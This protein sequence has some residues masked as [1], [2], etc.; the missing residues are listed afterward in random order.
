MASDKY[1]LVHETPSVEDYMRVRKAAG[2]GAKSL[3][4]AKR[5]LP[6]TLF[7]AQARYKGEVVAFCRLI[8]DDG[9]FYAVADGVVM[10]EHQ[11]QGLGKL[12]LGE[13]VR[14]FKETAPPGAY[15]MGISVSPD[16]VKTVGLEKVSPPE[17]GVYCWLP[18]TWDD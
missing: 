11:R 15:L 18:A 1:E 16:F 7:A 9:L 14:H 4:A 13:C 17:V 12:V 10:P 2:L 6:N 3:E 8:G 5:G